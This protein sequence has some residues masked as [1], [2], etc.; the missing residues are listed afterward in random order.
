MGNISSKNS[1]SL[2]SIIVLGSNTI[3]SALNTKNLYATLF[4]VYPRKTQLDVLN[5]NFLSLG[6]GKPIMAKTTP[7]S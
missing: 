1:A 6:S 7:Y 5:H 3:L 4:F 2:A